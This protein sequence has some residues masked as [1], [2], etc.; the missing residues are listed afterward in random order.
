M[1]SN[2]SSTGELVIDD[3]NSGHEQSL[4]D[5]VFKNVSTWV[6][7][8]FP[9]VGFLGGVSWDSWT[10]GRVVSTLDLWILG[11]YLIVGLFS[12]LLFN[13]GWQKWGVLA[14]HFCVGTLLSAMVILYAKSAASIGAYVV[15]ST[16]AVLMILNEFWGENKF[17]QVFRNIL[18]WLVS[19][20]YFQFLFPHI[21]QSISFVWFLL[22]I[23][24]SNSLL[25]VFTTLQRS[26]F[27]KWSIGLSCIWFLLWFVNLFPPIPLVLKDQFVGAGL[28]TSNYG[29]ILLAEENYFHRSRIELPEG[30][31]LAYLS[32]VF[33]PNGVDADLE[34]RWWY[35]DSQG[36]SQLVDKVKLKLKKGGRK[37]GWRFYSWKQNMKEG[38]WIVETAVRGGPVISRMGFEFSFARPKNKLDSVSAQVNPPLRKLK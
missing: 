20:M 15:V 23:V 2:D 1:H 8:W 35:V 4:S 24:F 27:I 12:T 6:K 5:P 17:D 37:K 29:A 19:T 10:L 11:C 3:S 14:Y 9:L 26:P 25:F 7:R 34:H 31:R 32:S 36:R 30:K 13:R 38:N 22:A 33:A 18:L 16:V 21:F 28:N